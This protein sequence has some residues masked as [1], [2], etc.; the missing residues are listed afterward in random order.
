M[1]NPI[2]FIKSFFKYE[3]KVVISYKVRDKKVT[4]NISTYCGNVKQF[5][6]TL[7]TIA[8]NMEDQQNALD[9]VQDIVSGRQNQ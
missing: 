9:Q 8:D 5:S 6:D 2:P 1:I 7:R 3:Q 4:Y